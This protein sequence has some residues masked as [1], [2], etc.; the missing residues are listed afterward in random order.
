MTDIRYEES[1]ESKVVFTTLPGRGYS[2]DVVAWSQFTLFPE[3]ST[4]DK[5]Y[6]LIV[7]SFRIVC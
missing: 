6:T 4:L 5:F 7:P 3:F 1:K 2:V